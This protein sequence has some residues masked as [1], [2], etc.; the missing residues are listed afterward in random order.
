MVKYRQEI[1]AYTFR[2]YTRQR[3]R[4]LLSYLFN[5]N[6][7]SYQENMLLCQRV[8]AVG[9][10]TRVITSHTCCEIFGRTEFAFDFHWW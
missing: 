8:F 5:V 1:I 9:F 3:S 7:S 4:Q 6:M 10:L 2:N